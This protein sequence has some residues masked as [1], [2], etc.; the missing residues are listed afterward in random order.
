MDHADSADS[1]AGSHIRL[2]CRTLVFG[3]ILHWHDD[4]RRKMSL[5]M[6]ASESQMDWSSKTPDQ[7]RNIPLVCELGLLE[8]RFAKLEAEEARL[9]KHA[10]EQGWVELGGRMFFANV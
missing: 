10:R 4:W 8:W 5:F 9:C 7:K 1:K 2:V 6:C 3:G